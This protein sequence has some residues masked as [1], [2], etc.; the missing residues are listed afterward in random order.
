MRRAASVVT[1]DMRRYPGL[2]KDYLWAS[3][4]WLLTASE[5][6]TD[7]FRCASR[8]PLLEVDVCGRQITVAAAVESGTLRLSGD[9]NAKRRLSDLLLG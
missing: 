9:D 4:C 3:A 5:R 1:I 7:G 8:E 6:R 2:R